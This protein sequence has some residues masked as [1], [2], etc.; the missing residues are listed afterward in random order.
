MLRLPAVL[1]LAVLAAAAACSDGNPARPSRTVTALSI[2]GADAVLTGSATSYT[3]TIT[4]ADGTTQTAT[5]TWISSNGAVATVDPTGRLEARAHGSTDLTASY[6]DRRASKTVRI[7]NNYAGTW[8]GQYVVRACA[9]SGD[10]QDHD[11]GWCR[12][13][14]GRVGSVHSFSIGFSQTGSD[15]S[16]ITASWDGITGVVTPDGRLQLRGTTDLWDWYHYDVVAKQQISSW[17]TIL[18]GADTMTGRW[19]ENL[20]SLV[21]RIGSAQTEHEIVTM[22]RVSASLTSG[23]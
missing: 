7:V 5:P 9:D 8:S 20:T 6:Q 17:E 12:Q 23:K 2:S 18:T 3:A 19:S 10:L 4:R 11:G 21:F 13:G 14:P 1:C 15:L 16:E 22:T